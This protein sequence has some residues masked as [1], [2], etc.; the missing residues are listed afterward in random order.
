MEGYDTVPWWVQWSNFVAAEKIVS[1]DVGLF[2]LVAPKA[3]VLR[4]YGSN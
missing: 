1:G 3:F 4:L 2:V